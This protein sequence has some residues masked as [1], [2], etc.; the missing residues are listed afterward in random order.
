MN[1][2]VLQPEERNCSEVWQNSS[3]YFCVTCQMAEGWT[4]SSRCGYRVLVSFGLY[5]YTSSHLTSAGLVEVMCCG[6][7]SPSAEPPSLRPLIHHTN[8]WWAHLGYLLLPLCKRTWHCHLVLLCVPSE[9]AAVSEL[10][11]PEVKFVSVI[12]KLIRRFPKKSLKLNC[13]PKL[14]TVPKFWGACQLSLIII[15]ITT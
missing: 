15:L 4:D 3:R 11:F 10:S 2:F 9:R 6:V 12:N 5:M 8:L 13:K 14:D 7:L 1:S